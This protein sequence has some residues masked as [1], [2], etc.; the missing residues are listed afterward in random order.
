MDI[1][2][3][4]YLSLLIVSSLIC[5]LMQ[6]CAKLEK[7]NAATAQH[8]QQEAEKDNKIGMGLAIEIIFKTG[9]NCD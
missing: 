8:S 1:K 6:E 2:R 4:V 9:R 7:A 5:N 3:Y